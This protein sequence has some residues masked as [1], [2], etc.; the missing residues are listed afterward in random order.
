MDHPFACT[1]GPRG[2]SVV[3][4]RRLRVTSLTGSLT[5][6][7]PTGDEVFPL[8]KAREAFERSL[9]HHGVGV[10]S[11]FTTILRSVYNEQQTKVRILPGICGGY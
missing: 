10:A 9:L 7:L 3:M 8:S 6:C 1:C 4:P 11:S 5:G 2:L